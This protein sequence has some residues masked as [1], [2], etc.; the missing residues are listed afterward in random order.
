MVV[1]PASSN[2]NHCFENNFIFK[3]SCRAYAASRRPY[4]TAS[5]RLNLPDQDWLTR[6][7]ESSISQVGGMVV[8]VTGAAGFVGFHT[9]LALKRRG[10]GVVGLDNFNDY[11]PI[12]LKHARQEMLINEGV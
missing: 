6:A 2:S 10:D 3:S 11:Y 8:L 7:Q 5:S 9:S 4:L 1:T 12:H